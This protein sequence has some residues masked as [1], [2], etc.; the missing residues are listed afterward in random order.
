MHN[1]IILACL[2][3]PK[4]ETMETFRRRGIAKWFWHVYVMWYFTDM[5]NVEFNIHILSWIVF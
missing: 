4:T 1:L 2:V 3:G 5:K